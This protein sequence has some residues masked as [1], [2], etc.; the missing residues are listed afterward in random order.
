MNPSNLFLLND[1]IIN[2][3][4]QNTQKVCSALKLNSHSLSN[5]VGLEETKAQSKSLGFIFQERDSKFKIH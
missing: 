2:Y 5:E 3:F 1:N 4:Q